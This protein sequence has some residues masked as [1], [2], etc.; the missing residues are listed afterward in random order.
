MLA[1]LPG[2]IFDGPENGIRYNDPGN[3]FELNA[4]RLI[5]LRSEEHYNIGWDFYIELEE[6]MMTYKEFIKNSEEPPTELCKYIAA[7]IGIMALNHYYE[8]K[9][10]DW[11][12]DE[13][14]KYGLVDPSETVLNPLDT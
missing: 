9:Q 8:F 3:S 6:A 10:S 2:N 7:G 5:D 14:K 13:S 1:W 11:H 4:G 12:K